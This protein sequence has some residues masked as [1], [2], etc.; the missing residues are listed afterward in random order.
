MQQLLA[1]A[2]PVLINALHNAPSGAPDL[3]IAVTT[4]NMGAG[5]F[6][7]SVSGCQTPDMGRF[8]D[9]ARSAGDPTTCSSNR[10]NS[11]EYFFV[12]GASRNYSGDLATAVGC[13]VQAGYDG[14]H[15]RHLLSAM[16]AALGDPTRGIVVPETNAGFLRPN[17]RLA[18]VLATN[19]WDCSAP[20][21]SLLFDPNQTAVSDPLGPPSSFRCVEFGL[22]CDGLTANDGRVP[23]TAGGP[24]QN[25]RSNDAYAAID[26]QHSLTPLQEF[27]DF[28]KRIKPDVV[29]AGF[30]GVDD[31]FRVTV[32]E[33]GIPF[34][35]VTCTGNDILAGPDI[36]IHQ[37]VESF[38][39]HGQFFSVCQYYNDAFAQ[40]ASLILAP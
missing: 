5:A 39:A 18:I 4:S 37:F 24:Y 19:Y 26:P 36:R 9:T 3:H 29:V 11:G 2:M 13:L 23:R 28:L 34:L 22:T 1:S 6:T 27:I 31:P 35:G 17:A 20:P 25:C 33:T 38:G 7:S 32:D 16:R 14:C 40:I 21:D 8:I 12:D 10:L 30:S 15:Y